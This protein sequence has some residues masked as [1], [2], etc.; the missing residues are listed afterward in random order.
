MIKTREFLMLPE[1][2]KSSSHVVRIGIG[3]IS[4]GL[5]SCEEDNCGIVI[6]APRMISSQSPCLNG[7]LQRFSGICTRSLIKVSVHAVGSLFFEDARQG[8][9]ESQ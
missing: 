5:N 3:S 4:T 7:M 2:K 8:G 9:E 6:G 1:P